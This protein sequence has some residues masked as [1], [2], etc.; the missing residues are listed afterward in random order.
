MPAT[1]PDDIPRRDAVLLAAVRAG[2]VV[3]EWERIRLSDRLEVEV[4]RDA[5]KWQLGDKLVRLG[6]SA[7]IQQQI[8]DSLGAVLLTPL[9]CDIRAREARTAGGLVGPFPQAGCPTTTRAY[10]QHSGEID[11]ALPAGHAG[12]VAGWKD[13][14]LTLD[15]WR[16]PGMATNYGFPVPA[17]EVRS[18]RWRGIPVR[19]SVSGDPQWLIQLDHEAHG[20]GRNTDDDP[21]P[22]IG[23]H[24]DYS[25]LV[26]LGRRAWVD[27]HDAPLGAVYMGLHGS[28]LARLVS[29]EGAL[30]ADRLPGVPLL[31][32]SGPQ[33]GRL[34][35]TPNGAGEVM[36][37]PDSEP[38]AEQ[39]SVSSI[40]P[41]T[42]PG[43]RAPW[44]AEL[45][46]TATPLGHR[47][48]VWLGY[49]FG[50]APREI[51]G[52]E[53]DPTILSYSAHCRRGGRFLGVRP[54]GEPI[55][56]GGTPL[57]LPGDDSP[58]H[59]C[60]ATQSEA[61][62]ACLLPGET[63]PHGLR[64]SVRELVE[65]ARVAGTLRPKH[66]LPTPGSL[67]ILARGG[68]NPL[69]GGPGHVRGV[70]EV[71]GEQYLGIGGN[72][73]DTVRMGWHDLDAADLVA[74]VER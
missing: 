13:W 27:G 68:S 20:A 58:W 16:K 56:E 43:S 42:E 52:P 15:S 25:Q 14:C 8:A 39:S 47:L 18:G 44:H 2:D 4:T 66:W 46:L 45:D 28:D 19:R 62:R 24:G 31:A 59:W 9:L 40:P 70:V 49:Q 11:E 37:P 65:D 34:D 50:L 67:A 71:D 55:W 22:E 73:G 72:E 10:V 69:H 64:V 5:P 12:M 23:G 3:F 53:H 48:V 6:V 60:A 26:A 54:G 21:E 74:W 1:Y 29:H 57:P 51:P 33:T 63:P 30:P 41:D 36:I 17:G 38:G 35:P 61:L 7:Y 32:L